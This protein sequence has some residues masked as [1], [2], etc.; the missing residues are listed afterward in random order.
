MSL[1]VLITSTKN[2]TNDTFVTNK[3]YDIQNGQY[4]KWEQTKDSLTFIPKGSAVY[5]DLVKNYI[6][7]GKIIFTLRFRDAQGQER[8]IDFPRKELTENGVMELLEY[9]VQVT[10]QDCKAL[11]VS[12]FNQE[13]S[14][15]AKCYHEKLGFHSI[16]NQLIFLGKRAKGIKS[17][18]C[19]DLKIGSHGD[20]T[21]W[22]NLVKE[23]VLGHVPMELALAVGGS[24][25]VV[26]YLRRTIP[27]EN[28]IFHAIGDS[29]TGKTC[30]ALLAVSCCAAPSF[31]G[32]STVHNFAD[33][34]NSLLNSI[35]SSFTTLIDEGSLCHYNCSNLLYSLA[36]GKEKARLTKDFERKDSASFANTIIIT[37]ER[38]LLNT[39][40]EFS[41]LLVRNI[42]I[43]GEVWTKSAESADRIRSVIENNYGFL[44]SKIANYILEFEEENSNDIFELFDY[45]VTCFVEDAKEN[46]YYNHL[47]ERASKQYAIIMVSVNLIEQVMEI[48]LQEDKIF[49]F[50]IDHSLVRDVNKADI[51]QRAMDYFLQY[52]QSHF[53]QFI[54]EKN[55]EFIPTVCLG[56]IEKKFRAVTLKNGSISNK[57][58]YV[59]DIV[60]EKILQEGGFQD[61]RIVLSKWKDIFG[62]LKSEKDR[63][64][65]EIQIAD[66]TKVKGYIICVPCD[67]SEIC[68]LCDD[69][70]KS[71]ER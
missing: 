13:S 47:T 55:D 60:F 29:S 35:P 48:E 68:L 33:T 26:D 19:G 41:G 6:D 37:S 28:V 61:K 62:Y 69:S 38:S 2:N 31:S 64:I 14:A 16:N 8:E 22:K 9:G 4:G 3:Q 67:D 56:R 42:E 66:S 27:L 45:W 70:E 63:Y 36:M 7:S 52:V 1:K 30:S 10:K 54:T 34:V 21:V 50:L 23:E 24:G 71:E 17:T 53:S 25:I 59:S 57:R 51:G 43:M 11:L 39:T 49:Q 46:G 5:L 20:Y 12:I 32:E 44:A 18:Y 40:D 65:S 58:I 15:P